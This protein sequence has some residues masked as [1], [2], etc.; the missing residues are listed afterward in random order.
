MNILLDVASALGYL[1]SSD[2]YMHLN[3]HPGTVWI[4]GPDT[5]RGPARAVKLTDPAI[6][7][8]EAA[9]KLFYSQIPVSP[10]EFRALRYLPPE[11][12]RK[13]TPTAAAD[14]WQFGML[15]YVLFA[16]RQ[17]YAGDDDGGVY[18]DGAAALPRLVDRLLAARPPP[19]AHVAASA[20]PPSVV[21]LIYGSCLVADPRRRSPM[22]EVLHRLFAL[23]RNKPALFGVTD[24]MPPMLFETALAAPPGDPAAVGGG[25]GGGGA[26]GGAPERGGVGGGGGAATGPAP[27]AAAGDGG[28][29]PLRR[30]QWR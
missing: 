6:R 9:P 8:P 12:A 2:D 22:W 5:P 23:R 30:G 4:P 16:E 3:V 28:R 27:A 25:G 18:P 11:V 24:A 13:E 10:A 29:S 1:H 19:R 26:G 14:V 21:D 7:P 17:P 15:A 20:A